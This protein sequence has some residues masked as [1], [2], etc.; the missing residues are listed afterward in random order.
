MNELCRQL[1]SDGYLLQTFYNSLWSLSRVTVGVCLAV[2]LGISLG[3][4]RH[5]IPVRYRYH[6]LTKFLME[7]LTFQPPLAWI[8]IIVMHF[9]IGEVSAYII[10]MIGGFSPIFKSSYEGAES[11]P[12]VIQKTAASME[13]TSWTYFRH[14][15]L[16]A[17]SPMIFTGI[18]NSLAM[19][20][21]SIIGAEMIIGGSYG[22]GYS[23]QINRLNLE[24]QLMWVDFITIG[25]LGY[26]LHFLSI[27]LEQFLL[28]WHERSLNGGGRH[29]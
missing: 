1:F 4:L 12:T 3:L 7:F 25:I 11:I 27:K 26:S 29:D 18:R 8:G 5:M 15:I 9:G 24:Q 6:A 10:V 13:L 17:S 14:I 28:P 16:P 23:L 21:M 20:W 2:S 19:G 22:L